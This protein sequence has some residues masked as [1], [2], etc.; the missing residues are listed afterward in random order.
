MQHFALL[1]E[2]NFEI[3]KIFETLEF[4]AAYP[5]FFP[6]IEKILDFFNF[7]NFIAFTILILTRFFIFPPPT[8]KINMASLLFNLLIFNPYEINIEITSGE[9]FEPKL[10]REGYR[11]RDQ[12]SNLMNI[13]QS[14]IQT[15]VNYTYD[16][17]IKH[18]NIL[19]II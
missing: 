18:V 16:E 19:Q 9:I 13:T 3:W 7:A 2:Q 15:R 14:T 4:F 17:I 8:E 5:F 10:N 12:L 11:V 1:V 6:I